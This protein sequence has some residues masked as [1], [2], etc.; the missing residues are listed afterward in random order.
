MT[1]DEIALRE[2]L[3]HYRAWNEAEFADRVRRAGEQTL[4]E[5][6]QA[7]LDLFAFGKRIRPT[8]SGYAQ[9]QE[10]MAL[11]TYYSRLR[12]FEEKR[13]RRDQSV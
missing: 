4:A 8:P 2:A 9:Q 1:E 6:W 11:Q 10:T 13:R 3:A 5:K 12:R 7:F